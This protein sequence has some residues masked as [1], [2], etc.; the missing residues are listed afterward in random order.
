MRGA[1]TRRRM[2]LPVHLIKRARRESTALRGGFCRTIA[3]S[4]PGARNIET[5][6]K[7]LRNADKFDLL[8]WLPMSAGELGYGLKM[9]S[10]ILIVEDDPL[11]AIMIEGFL[12][13]LGYEL[14]GCEGS[15]GGAIARLAS[16]DFDAVILDVHLANGETS[17]PIGEALREGGI[18]FIVTTGDDIAVGSKYGASPLL[19]KPFALDAFAAALAQIGV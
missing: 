5:L 8:S 18:P 14:V 11:V 16:S 12:D 4:L 2:E 3:N 1:P 10:R 17:E 15:L 13:V 7:F 6:R 19:R 9:T